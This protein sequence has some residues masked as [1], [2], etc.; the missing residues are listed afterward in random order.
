MS[1][2][3][4]GE[5]VDHRRAARVERAQDGRA[6][7]LRRATGIA[8]AVRPSRPAAALTS[9]DLLARGSWSRGRR[10]RP[11]RR[12]PPARRRTPRRGRRRGSGCCGPRGRRCTRA[13]PL[14]RQVEQL[15]VGAEEPV[16]ADDRGR[17]RRGPE[18]VDDLLV[19]VDVRVAAQLVGVEERDVGEPRRRPRGRRRRA[20]RGWARCRAR[21]T[22]CAG[23]GRR[24]SVPPSAEKT[25]STPGARARRSRRRA[26]Q[27]RGPRGRGAR[28]PRTSSRP[29][30]P[31][32]PATRTFMRRRPEALADAGVPRRPAELAPCAARSTRPASSCPSGPASGATRRTSQAGTRSGFAASSARA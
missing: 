3:R 27:R 23:H 21:G 4:C 19:G 29:R 8:L 25:A 20:A 12:R 1:T 26:A 16:G 31:V 9:V 15:V 2:G 30:W 28:A 14:A 7:A 32:A 5:E 24:A 6:D 17:E 13:R 22:A 18:R 11:P 10:P